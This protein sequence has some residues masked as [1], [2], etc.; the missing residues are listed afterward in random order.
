[1]MSGDGE[2]A[3]QL[4][5]TGSSPHNTMSK[6]LEEGLVVRD[7]GSKNRRVQLEA[8]EER[9]MMLM[10]VVEE[11]GSFLLQLSRL[12]SLLVPGLSQSLVS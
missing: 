10:L 2:C 1:M 9:Q 12:L 6:T 3:V 7:E 8:T 5:W 4:C 11:K